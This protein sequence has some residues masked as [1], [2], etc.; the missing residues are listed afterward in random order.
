MKGEDYAQVR[1]PSGEVRRIFT[2][3]ARRRSDRLAQVDHE[4][5]EIGKAGRSHMGRRPTVRGSVMNPN[6][7]RARRW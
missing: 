3:I 7:H 6:D 2:S 1:M 5:I 4:N